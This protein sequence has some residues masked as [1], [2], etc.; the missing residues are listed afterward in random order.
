MH[1]LPQQQ[2]PQF[3][4]QC[5]GSDPEIS[6]ARQVA[7]ILG[8]LLCSPTTVR[9]YLVP[10]AQIPTI[11][12]IYKNEIPGRHVILLKEYIYFSACLMKIDPASG[13]NIPDYSHNQLNYYL[14]SIPNEQADKMAAILTPEARENQTIE[15][16]VIA[17]SS[18]P[19]VLSLNGLLLKELLKHKGTACMVLSCQAP[20]EVFY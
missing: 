15:E 11:A 5:S 18:I 13:R 6:L 7:P 4:T 17:L 20:S 14:W 3:S 19:G 9:D 2:E 1:S 16:L 12:T 8:D 10:K